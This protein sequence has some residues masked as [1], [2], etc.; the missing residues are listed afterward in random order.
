MPDPL[1]Q[2]EQGI[3]PDVNY[4]DTKTPLKFADAGG[5]EIGGGA[6]DDG[7]Y[8][9]FSNNGTE[10][11]ATGSQVT[12]SGSINDRK[13]A[14]I[15][16]AVTEN[17]RAQRLLAN[18]GPG[19]GGDALTELTLTGANDGLFGE[20][21]DPL[22]TGKRGQDQLLLGGSAGS[23]PLLAE[24]DEISGGS[25][26]ILDAI[27]SDDPDSKIAFNSGRVIDPND[28]E[29]VDAEFDDENLSGCL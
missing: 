3:A 4:G 6:I 23:D 27:F 8:R 9:N 10:V 28:P 21:G 29:F 17:I 18:L 22:L 26:N 15:E 20:G 14:A 5:D 2:A 25:D 13:L 24:L 1:A 11:D 7:G 19:Q 12:D 16:A